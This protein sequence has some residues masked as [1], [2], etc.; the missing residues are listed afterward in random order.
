MTNWASLT[1]GPLLAQTTLGLCGKNGV[2]SVEKVAVGWV[3][4]ALWIEG[5]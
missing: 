4:L 3:C 1:S 2:Y 5:E